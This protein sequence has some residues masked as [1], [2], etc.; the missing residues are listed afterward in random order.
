[1]VSVGRGGG[2]RTERAPHSCV[3]HE[4]VDDGSEPFV[5]DLRRKE[6]EKAV[7]LVRVSS[8]GRRESR[9]IGVLR[10]L[11]GAHL[12]LKLSAEALDSSENAHRVSLTEAL[13]QQI[14]VVPD[15][16]LDASAHVH[17]LEREVRGAGPGA[18]TLLPGDGEDA[19]DGPILD[20]LGDR[21]HAPRIER[22]AVG[23]LA[24]D[25]RRPAVSRRPLLRCGGGVDGPRRA[26]VR[27][28]RR[29]GAGGVVHGAARTTSFT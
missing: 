8:Q 18:S 17:E 14:D 19:L 24:R 7:E 6:L 27:R 10:R 23:T 3:A 15:A 28:G 22:E 11:D 2:E 26:A 9:W 25:G 12:H 21:G 13:V 20:E 5:R 4:G 1:M 16:R 29:R